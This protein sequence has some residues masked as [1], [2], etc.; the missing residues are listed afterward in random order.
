MAMENK[1]RTAG[2]VTELLEVWA[3]S[4]FWNKTTLQ[5]KK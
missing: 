2:F 3:I 1:N 5:G 4:S